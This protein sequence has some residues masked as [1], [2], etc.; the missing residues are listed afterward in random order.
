LTRI[1]ITRQAY[2]SSLPTSCSSVHRQATITVALPS[3]RKHVGRRC[4][5]SEFNHLPSKHYI[6]TS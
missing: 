2:R 3:G 1:K 6:S 5:F 4:D